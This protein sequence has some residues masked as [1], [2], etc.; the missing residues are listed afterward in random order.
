MK[1][2]KCAFKDIM[3]APKF[4]DLVAEYGEECGIDG[5]PKPQA[6]LDLYLTL[7]AHGSIQTIAAWKD[8]DL[9]GFVIVLAPVMGHYST[10][11]CTTE[12]LFVAKEHRSSGAG[13]ALL[14]AAEDYARE[15]GS[16]GLLV[17]APSG[18]PLEAVLP[19]VGYKET[20][21][22]FFKNV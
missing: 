6:K 9:I 1:I 7:D 4:A 3:E 17:S 8:G 5:L 12:S 15:V 19:R 22:V 2:S 14:R 18:G 16:P 21:R 11:I 13:L 20:N 10:T